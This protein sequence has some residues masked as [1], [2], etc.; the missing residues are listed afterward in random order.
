ML[1]DKITDDKVQ[2]EVLPLTADDLKKIN[3][4][5]V[6]FDWKEISKNGKVFKLVSKGDKALHGLMG[7]AERDGFIYITHIERV[8]AKGKGGKVKEDSRY[9]GVPQTMMAYA[10]KVSFELGFEG[11]V[12][13]FAKTKL[14]EYYKRICGAQPLANGRDLCIFPSQA[15]QLINMWL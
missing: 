13:F 14:T 2:T 5:L 6:V 3:R 12:S 11:Y 9:T 15:E 8:G 10:C 4:K 7:F 1:I